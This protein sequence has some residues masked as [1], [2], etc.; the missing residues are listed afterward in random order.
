[1][2]AKAKRAA[3]KLPPAENRL[4]L[5]LRDGQKARI[6]AITGEGWGKASEFVCEAIEAALK[7]HEAKAK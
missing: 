2:V 1:M 6:A 3:R 4:N 7:R 5:R